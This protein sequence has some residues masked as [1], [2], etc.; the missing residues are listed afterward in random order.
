M[1]TGRGGSVPSHLKTHSGDDNSELNADENAST[2][3]NASTNMSYQDL[4]LD[5]QSSK[6][7]PVEDII[8]KID[9]L[10]S[11]INKCFDGLLEKG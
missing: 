5:E 4:D 3:S 2:I 6:S 9:D 7:K 10:D 11:Q 8:E 1:K